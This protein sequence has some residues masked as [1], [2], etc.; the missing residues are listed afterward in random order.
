LNEAPARA[1][2]L[3]HLVELAEL[4]LLPILAVELRVEEVDPL[5]PALDLAPFEAAGPE[6]FSDALPPFGGKLGVECGDEFYFLGVGRG[7]SEDQSLLFF[8]RCINK[9]NTMS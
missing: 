4:P 2:L 1:Y 3:V 5:L 9:T 6:F 7:T 8:V